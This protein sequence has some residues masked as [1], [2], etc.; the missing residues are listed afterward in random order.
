MVADVCEF[1]EE[2][3]SMLPTLNS[4]LAMDSY[5]YLIEFCDTEPKPPADRV[6]P[7]SCDW[8]RLN[9]GKLFGVSDGLGCRSR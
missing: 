4:G 3:C 9:P 5:S 6:D 7:G 1:Y 8:F 2:G